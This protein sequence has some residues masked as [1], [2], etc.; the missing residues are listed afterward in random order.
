MTHS[1]NN[2]Y[3][4]VTLIKRGVIQLPGSLA[5]TATVAAGGT[6]TGGGSLGNL[7]N[8]GV[9]APGAGTSGV[10]HAATYS[11]PGALNIAFDGASHNALQ[12]TGDANVSG[13]I[14]NLS[15]SRFIAG[16]YS[17]V[18]AGS[19]TGT[20][21]TVNKPVSAFLTFKDRYTP[22]DVFVDI[23]DNGTTFTSVGQTGNQTSVGTALD[24]VKR[25]VTSPASPL[26]QAIN[27]INFMSADQA[28]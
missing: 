17:V 2:P 27:A 7:T 26:Q 16:Q 5:G 20:F 14:L 24:N 15:G 4:G 22:T 18:N 11:G 12:V 19:V 25:S 21:G 3:R 9:V 23:K 13:G 1:G 6:L 10:M 28:R 8:N